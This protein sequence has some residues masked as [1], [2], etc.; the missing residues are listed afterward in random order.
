MTQTFKLDRLKDAVDVATTLTQSWFR[1]HSRAIGHLVPRLFRPEH[2]D[3][4]VVALRPDLELSTIEAF[5]RHA[6]LVSDVR[7]PADNDRFGW[8]CVMQHY[9]TP[10]RLLDW[11]ENALVALYFAASADG[12]TDGE[13]WAMLPWALNDNAGAG[14]GIPMLSASP[15]VKYLL[16]EPYWAAG[17]PEKLAADVG[18]KEPV[19]SP[20]AVEPPV[21]FPRMAVQ[22]STFT[23]HPYPECSKSILEVLLDPK[24]LVRYIIP[25]SAKPELL[26]QLRALGLSDRHLFP[27]LE[28]LSRMIVSDNTVIAYSPPNPPTCSGEV[29]ESLGS[30]A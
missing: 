19:R 25:A 30:A 28:G 10:T 14:W 11:T 27:D 7:L 6:L 29:T 17:M 21:F 8:L 13:L 26:R 4:G 24:H 2:R 5:K 15:H 18:L 22:G 23:L 20:I 12:A 3:A 9:R 1:G 16:A